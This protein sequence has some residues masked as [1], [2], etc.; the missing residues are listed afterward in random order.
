MLRLILRRIPV[1]GVEQAR[2]GIL[3]P[4]P[5]KPMMNR[6]RRRTP[7]Q[8]HVP[9]SSFEIVK[10]RHRHFEHAVQPLRL[11]LVGV[12]PPEI[13]EAI[14]LV[15]STIKPDRKNPPGFRYLSRDLTAAWQSGV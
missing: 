13:A 1:K 4:V 14:P 2:L 9:Q 12:A 6:P 11:H 8:R 7:H 15:V 3:L 10:K 5:R